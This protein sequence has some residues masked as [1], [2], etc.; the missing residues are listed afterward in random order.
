M[1]E[2]TMELEEHLKIEFMKKFP[3]YEPK[4][5]DHSAMI[6]AENCFR[7]YFYR[8]VLGFVPKEDAIY[9]AW[10]SA[11]HK[12][13]EILE[14]EYG[15]GPNKPVK[16][17]EEKAKNSF[18]D[19]ALA[20]LTYWRKHGKDQGP[21]DKFSWMTQARLLESF[22][23]AFEWW[24]IEKKQGKIEVIA[25]EQAFNIRLPDGTYRSGRAD[26][27]IKWMGK[28]YGRDFKTTSKD[29]MFYQKT[30][31]PNEQFTG[32]T[33]CE[34]ELTGETIQGQIIEVLYNAKSTKTAQKGPEI[35][36]F[37]VNKTKWELDQ[38]L[39]EHIQVTKMIDL[40]RQEDVWPMCAVNCSFCEFHSVCKQG[41]EAQQMYQ[42]ESA[43][44][45]EPWDN[46]KVGK[47][48]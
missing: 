9:F 24:T 2:V 33:Y 8:I 1:Q 6:V 16:W 27:I 43:F 26:Q 20:G 17:D 39:K 31:V 23:K 37:P 21:E 19:A 13:R 41:S 14:C 18:A 36:E 12:F 45:V 30:L 32:Y 46:T 25:V 10:G 44:K 4:N 29:S 47:D 40:C 5:K 28:T 34:G 42:L 22:K 48:L 35:L 3:R 15:Y 38:W 11:Y 7:K